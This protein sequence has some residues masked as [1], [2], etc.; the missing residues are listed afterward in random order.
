MDNPSPPP[1]G[2]AP[3]PNNLRSPTNPRGCPGRLEGEGI[4]TSSPGKIAP[5]HPTCSKKGTA[6]PGSWSPPR[7]LHKEVLAFDFNS[8][9]LTSLTAGHV[10]DTRLC[11]SGVPRNR[12]T[13]STS[14]GR[15]PANRLGSLGPARPDSGGHPAST[16]ERFLPFLWR[17]RVTARHTPLCCQAPAARQPLTCSPQLTVPTVPYGAWFRL[18]QPLP[19]TPPP[20]SGPEPP[21]GDG[22]TPSLR[23]R[24]AAILAPKH[25]VLL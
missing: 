23:P 20:G 18:P 14:A 7:H 21:V 16:P 8:E 17:P 2:L 3:P 6:A 22:A 4:Q 19:R 5:P 12:R 1:R 11:H 9:S 15:P 24:R 25:P 13:Y 10:F